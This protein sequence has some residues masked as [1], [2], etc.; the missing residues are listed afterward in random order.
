MLIRRATLALALALVAYVPAAA[1]QQPSAP[2]DSLSRAEIRTALRAFYNNRAQGNSNALL[3]DMLGSKV[4][5]NRK[6]P[7]EAIVAS[8]TL[9]TDAHFLCLPAPP[10]DQAI[11]V[12]KSN[13][14]HVSVQRCG[15]SD[16]TADHFRLIYLDEKW[17]FVDFHLVDSPH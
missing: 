12:L 11:I 8:D 13:W 15:T 10:I 16:S 17:R 2:S 1:T 5:A 14:A 3:I 6:A 9:P 7:F 4:D